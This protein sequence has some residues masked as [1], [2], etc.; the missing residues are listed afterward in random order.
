MCEMMAGHNQKCFREGW[1]W[2]TSSSHRAGEVPLHQALGVQLGLQPVHKAQQLLHRQ[3]LHQRLVL[4]DDRPAAVLQD[5]QADVPA[6]E[7]EEG[8]GAL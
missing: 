7:R 6:G 1:D 4:L 3:A 2:K 8:R 5:Q